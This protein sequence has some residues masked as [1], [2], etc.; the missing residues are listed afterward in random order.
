MDV[1]MVGRAAA[2]LEGPRSGFGYNLLKINQLCKQRPSVP[3]TAIC[4]Q[5]F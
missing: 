5:F 4:P 2:G 3:E 1:I